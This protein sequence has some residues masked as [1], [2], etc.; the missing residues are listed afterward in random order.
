VSSDNDATADAVEA[1]R[2]RVGSTKGEGAGLRI[3]VTGGAAFSA[4]I[5]SVFEG[6]DTTLL[7]ITGSIVLALLVLIYRSPIFWA[8]PFFVVLLTEAATR[9]AGYLI[10]QAGL[11]ITGQGTGILI[12]LVFG[13]ATD[14]ALLLVARYRE[15]LERQEDTHAAM[16]TALRSAGPAILASGGTVVAALLTLLL[17]RVGGTQ[18][19]GPLGAGGVALAMLFSL[20]ALPAALLVVGRRAFWPSIPRAGQA[21]DHTQRGLFATLA[22]RIP[23]RAR[24]LWVG[25]TVVLVVLALGLTGIDP[26][27]TQQQ[28]FT[29][30]VEAVTGQEL[31]NEGFPA[32]TTA[33]A[34]VLVPRG[35]SVDDVRRG[36]EDAPQVASVGEARTGP[37]GTLLSV[38]LEGDPYASGTVGEIPA[39][40]RAA[41]EA[42]PGTLVGGP[43]AQE[44]DLREAANRDTLVVIPVALAVVLVILV[45]L[46]RSLAAPVLLL[47]T[48]IASNLAALGVGV[49]LSEHVYDFAAIDP[50]LPLLGFIFLAALGIDYNI[51]LAA[52]AREETARYG[53]RRGML[54]ALAVTGSVI[55]A[56]GV[57]LAATFATLA[58]LPL[59][60]LAQLGTVVAVGVLIDTLLVRS[61]LVPA[62]AYDLG[63][64]FWWPSR[65]ARDSGS[66]PSELEAIPAPVP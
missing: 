37:P 30:Q 32:G 10:G 8:V 59:V 54:R 36:L 38:V 29:D 48:V 19:I 61:I 60:V 14:Y 47:A 39:L 45:A 11:T 2:E 25:S 52:R 63:H 55:T 42:A 51:F 17:A 7:A 21:T 18:A 40:R 57:V 28:Q 53:A 20:T 50:T 5:S 6:V 3:A 23:G 31:L 12:V 15:E 43:T 58:L 62:L 13:A 46:L 24:V 34:S 35:A 9:G 16:W 1:L 26:T 66:R 27:L 41:R 56:A 33:P 4:D 44:Y 65:V 49:L 22:R 64:R